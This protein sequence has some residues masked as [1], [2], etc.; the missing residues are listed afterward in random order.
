MTTAVNVKKQ[1]REL[2]TQMVGAVRSQLR[3]AVAAFVDRDS[4]LANTVIER[5]DYIDNLYVY[6]EGKIFKLM[7][8]C[9]DEARLA[10]LR[11]SLKMAKGMEKIADYAENLAKQALY[12]PSGQ[13]DEMELDIQHCYE[14]VR[15]GLDQ[16]LKGFLKLDAK[17]IVRA[18]KK[19][20]ALD[21]LY[22]DLLRRIIQRLREPGADV[23]MLITEM[24]AA[25][26][27]EKIG[28]IIL[29]MSEEILSLI[30][31][32]RL[33]VHQ[34]LHMDDLANA[35]GK[36]SFNT[37]GI[38]GTR[39]GASVFKLGV[40]GK[41]EYIYKEGT[42]AKINREIERLK[43]WNEI[44]PGLVPEVQSTN[45]DQ[46]NGREVLVTNY[47][48][49]VTL[50]D[51]YENFEWSAKKRVTLQLLQLLERIWEKTIQPDPIPFDAISQIQS[52]LDAVFSMHPDF[53][54][55]QHS[56][57][58]FCG[59]RHP[60][61]STMLNRLESLSESLYTPFSVFIH[62]DFNSD[63]VLLT[64][65]DDKLRFV[66]VNRS[67]MGDYLQDISVFLISILRVP[68]LSDQQVLDIRGISEL[69]IDFAREFS[70]KHGDQLFE[71]RL[72]LLMARS[73]ITSTRFVNNPSQS[74]KMFL[75][76]MLKLENALMMLLPKKERGIFSPSAPFTE[77]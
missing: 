59:I 60:S 16:V 77:S 25:K 54:R 58:T 15:E 62:G 8:G 13:S 66:D 27:M 47:F 72:Q 50:K 19:E 53:V 52:R 22:A 3:T 26:H 73:L 71:P 18:A 57:I 31:G 63:N 10:V 7:T 36:A 14:Q 23:D 41:E 70:Q 2:V 44:E 43:K 45:S 39:S 4:Q 46:V 24:F 55:I 30:Y 17:T 9:S 38:W 76:G 35:R 12:L 5:D 28:D 49:G 6:T 21:A 20:A 68:I 34:V 42:P 67:R 1:A 11:T 69:V 74:K 65:G 61:L 37:E 32:E 48:H 29:D 64:T 51:L 75:Q 33:K 40:N 56:A